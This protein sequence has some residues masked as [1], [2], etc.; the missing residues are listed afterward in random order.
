[1]SCDTF[2]TNSEITRIYRLLASVKDVPVVWLGSELGLFDSTIIYGFYNS[3][4]V[5][6]EGAGGSYC[7]LEIE[8]LS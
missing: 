7:S 5:I 3:F 2:L 1:M 8:G 4:N 6:L